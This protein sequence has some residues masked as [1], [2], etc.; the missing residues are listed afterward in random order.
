MGPSCWPQSVPSAS[1][2]TSGCCCK[3]LMVASESRSQC[4]EV[5]T[6]KSSSNSALFVIRLKN[7]L[8]KDKNRMLQILGGGE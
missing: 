5:K 3:V 8:L 4:Q 7:H 1:S 2:L 6:K